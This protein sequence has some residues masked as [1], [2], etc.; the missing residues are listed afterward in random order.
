LW[1]V[2]SQPTAPTPNLGDQDFLSGLSP[3]AFGVPT[4]LL[5]GNPRQGP[6]QGAISRSQLN[7]GFLSDNILGF[8]ITSARTTS[9][10]VDIK[11]WYL[12]DTSLE[13]YHYA[14]P[15]GWILGSTKFGIILS[16]TLKYSVIHHY[17]MLR[18]IRQ[19]LGQRMILWHELSNEERIYAWF[20]MQSTQPWVLL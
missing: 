7:P 20:T 11:N 15:P 14:N 17:R 18:N 5:Q 13:H 2:G 9:D 4:P 3:L 19:G 8:T 12:S 10:V 6:L 1:W 16:T